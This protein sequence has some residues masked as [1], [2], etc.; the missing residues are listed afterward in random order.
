[1]FWLFY[2]KSKLSFY[3]FKGKKDGVFCPK[4]P[5]VLWFVYE[6]SDGSG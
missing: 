4:L 3:E 1:M 5:L 2:R 6:N